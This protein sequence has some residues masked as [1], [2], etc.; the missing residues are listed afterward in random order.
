MRRLREPPPCEVGA[1]EGFPRVGFPRVGPPASWLGAGCNS[2]PSSASGSTSTRRNCSGAGL[3][4]RTRISEGK[5]L[6]WWG[7]PGRVRP[8][9]ARPSRAQNLPWCIAQARAVIRAARSVIHRFIKMALSAGRGGK[10]RLTAKYLYT[11]V[12]NRPLLWTRQRGRALV[13]RA[14][15][16]LP[17]LSQWAE[18]ALGKATEAPLETEI[19]VRR[20]V[21]CPEGERPEVGS[22]RGR[23]AAQSV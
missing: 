22:V 7:S 13:E 2:P 4:P 23:Q 16:S 6:R 9:R 20:E 1:S 12:G 3:R 5:S 10:N 21:D 19:P 17:C 8:G 11:G 18:E 15:A 14:P